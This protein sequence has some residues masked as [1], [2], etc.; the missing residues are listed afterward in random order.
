MLYG[1]TSLRQITSAGW[2][3]GS[4]QTAAGSLN[5]RLASCTRRSRAP[6]WARISSVH[7]QDGS[8]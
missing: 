8:G 2:W 3:P 6:A 1:A 7:S 5:P 4:C